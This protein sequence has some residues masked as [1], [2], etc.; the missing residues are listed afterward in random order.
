[1][2]NFNQNVSTAQR[3]HTGAIP[4]KK[5]RYKKCV[6]GAPCETPLSLVWYIAFFVYYYT[7]NTK[8]PMSNKYK[9]IHVDTGMTVTMQAAL[10][11]LSLSLFVSVPMIVCVYMWAR[12]FDC[13]HVCGGAAFEHTTIWKVPLI[14]IWIL[15]ICTAQR[16]YV[17]RTIYILLRL[18]MHNTCIHSR[19]IF[20]DVTMSISP[21]QH[22]AL[23]C[24]V[25]E[26]P[27]HVAF[28]YIRVNS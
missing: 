17:W 9:Y 26:W 28:C 27:R 20:T 16:Q 22:C 14:I 6:Y 11:S 2:G 24:L 1:M 4:K 10:L 12:A 13:R 23:V 19:K 15:H 5:K 21:I 7:L 8:I 25:V 18:S 3:A